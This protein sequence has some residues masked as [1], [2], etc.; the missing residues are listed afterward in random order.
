MR[1]SGPQMGGGKRGGAGLTGSGVCRAPLSKKDTAVRRKE[2]LDAVSPA[3]LEHLRSNARTMVTDKA[4]SVTVADILASASGDL[5]PAMAAVA[6]LAN[7]ELVPGGTSG[8]VS[9]LQGACR[10]PFSTRQQRGL[11]AF[12][13]PPRLPLNCGFVSPAAHGRAPRRAPGA[14]MAHRAGRDAGGGR[15][16]R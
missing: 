11:Q 12:V 5:R 8:Q 9:G 1:R 3:L 10:E 13:L 6:Q 2:L 14:E 4:A 7:Q 16:G 15:Q